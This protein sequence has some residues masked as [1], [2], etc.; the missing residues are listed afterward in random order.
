MEYHPNYFQFSRS[1]Q[2]GK[3]LLEWWASLP[4]DSGGRA[5][6]RRAD[7]PLAVAFCPVYQRLYARLREAG[8]PELSDVYKDRLA[9]AIGLLAHVREDVMMSKDEERTSSSYS[10]NTL[11]HLATLMS[12]SQKDERNPISELRFRRLLESP[13]NQALFVGLRRALPLMGYRANVIVLA[14]DVLGWGERVK[15]NWAYSY[16]WAEKD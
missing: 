14:N 12:A 15:K 5:M 8:M 4:T 6:L 1:S 10:E 16:R 3:V 9:A 11:P 7:S 2:A 13:D